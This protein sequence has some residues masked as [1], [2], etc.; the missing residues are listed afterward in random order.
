[1]GVAGRQLGEVILFQQTG[2][3]GLSLCRWHLKE[4]A[5]DADQSFHPPIP[6]DVDTLPGGAVIRRASGKSMA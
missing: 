6:G 3:R 1:M 2:P 5:T 4:R